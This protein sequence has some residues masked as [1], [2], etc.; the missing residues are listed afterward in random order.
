MLWTIAIIF[1]LLWVLGLANSVTLGGYI[2]LLAGVAIVLLLARIIVGSG[3]RSRPQKPWPFKRLR[4]TETP[5]G[6]DSMRPVA[7]R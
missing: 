3:R 4:K 2:H 7:D 1:A 5:H 6:E